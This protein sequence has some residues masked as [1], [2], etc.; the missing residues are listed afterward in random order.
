MKKVAKK[1]E[2][3]LEGLKKEIVQLLARRHLAILFFKYLATRERSSTV[4]DVN[5]LISYMR[6]D[7]AFKIDR[8]TIVD[9]FATLASSGIG[10][11]RG[12]EGRM[13]FDWSYWLF[14]IFATLKPDVLLGLEVKSLSRFAED[15]NLY[16]Q[17][18][19][20]V[21]KYALNLS[22][23]SPDPKLRP[24]IVFD[25]NET[26]ASETHIEHVSLDALT[27]EIERRGWYV[28]LSKIPGKSKGT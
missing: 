6:H 17:V 8:E 11:L 27:K 13:K 21:E 14:P 15:R 16:K 23:G 18:K 4:S 28:S 3:D 2:F 20:Q 24:D 26:T 5:Q 25:L 9:V 10:V 12:D 22:A 7:A 19:R 1:T